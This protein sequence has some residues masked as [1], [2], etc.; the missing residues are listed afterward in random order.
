MMRLYQFH[1]RAYQHQRRRH[2]PDLRFSAMLP[3]FYIMQTVRTA[4]HFASHHHGHT[5][6]GGTH[7]R[8]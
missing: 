4:H 3:N 7:V 1:R 2:Q 8:G 5:G 6:R